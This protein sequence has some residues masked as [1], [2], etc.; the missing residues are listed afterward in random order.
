MQPPG[1]RHGGQRRPLPTDVAEHLENHEAEEEEVETG[2][3]PCHDYER[4][5]CQQQSRTSTSQRK[6]RFNHRGAAQ[7][8]LDVESGEGTYDFKHTC[9]YV[10]NQ[11]NAVKYFI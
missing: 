10:N 1:L 7:L 11:S 3:D 5:L 2:T 9:P 6:R 8:S 4:H